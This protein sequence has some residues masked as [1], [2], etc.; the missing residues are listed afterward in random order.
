MDHKFQPSLITSAQRV[1]NT[2]ATYKR[3]YKRAASSCSTCLWTRFSQQIN[4]ACLCKGF[5]AC[6]D[7]DKPRVIYS[8]TAPSRMLPLVVDGRVPT[9]EEETECLAL[10]A[11]TLKEACASNM[12]VCGAGL[13]DS[14]HPFKDVFIT[15]PTLTCADH[16]EPFF[17]T[18]GVRARGGLSEMLCCFCASGQADVT[19]VELSKLFST[20]LP[21]CQTCI[22]GGAKIP[23]RT[24]IRNSQQRESR[25]AIAAQRKAKRDAQSIAPRGL[26]DEQP[27]DVQE[28][29][30]HPHENQQAQEEIRTT[31]S[32]PPRRGR[33]RG[34]GR[35]IR[36]GGRG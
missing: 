28:E 2:A 32:L 17:Y 6:G 3:C 30:H 21:V 10:A 4:Y 23:V 5:V 33:A 13:Y 11:E 27:H 19:D 7:C 15:Q 1:A 18:L 31:A 14:G 24:A 34:N 20:V 8:D 25:A 9:I 35:L 26:R 29:V 16:I 36:R 12:Y 22:T